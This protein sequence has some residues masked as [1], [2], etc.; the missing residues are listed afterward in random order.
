MFNRLKRL[1]SKYN[2]SSNGKSKWLLLLISVGVCFLVSIVVNYC[3]FLINGPT[4]LG[5]WYNKYWI[6]AVALFA[7]CMLLMVFF[8]H[9]L[10]DKPERLYLALVLCIGCF[11][12]YSFSLRQ[13]SW[14]VAIHFQ[15][16]LEWSDFGLPH[17]V[18][19]AEA[20][21]AYLPPD[22]PSDTTLEAL[23]KWEEELDQQDDGESGFVAAGA[24]K[25]LYKKI[26]SLP[27]SMVY[28]GLSFLGLSFSDRYILS[29]LVYVFIYGIVTYFGMRRLKSGKLIFATIAMFPTSIFIAANYSYDYWVNAFALT[30]AAYL[31]GELQRSD[32]LAKKKNLAIMLGSFFLA[33]GP[34]AIYFPIILLCLLIPRN[35][36]NTR[37]ECNLYRTVTVLLSLLVLMSFIA[38]FFFAIS[39]E[40]VVG[41]MRGG[42][43]VNSGE[44]IRFILSEP[45]RYACILMTFLV[46][47]L[48]PLNS[49]GYIIDLAYLNHAP[50]ICWVVSVTCLL[51]AVVFD[52]EACDKYVN[53][54]RNR[55]A[56]LAGVLLCI[57][58][59][60]TALY[61]S[62]TPVGSPTI[63]GCQFRY[64]LP[65]IFPFCIFIGTS[66]LPLSFAMGN[67]ALINGIYLV[68]LSGSL[69]FA[70]A[71]SVIIAIS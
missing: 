34:K 39:S 66:K 54:H 69:L 35:K 23:D 29:H 13:I 50:A 65:V 11:Y 25:E 9:E 31:V 4:S 24:K 17:S 68:V 8:R 20:Q 56:V 52:K 37:R 16:V 46:N 6:M 60:A 30:G 70:N 26:A 7:F 51:L 42:G 22:G 48:S 57:I 15:Y 18:S 63:Q 49:G 67:R 1:L 14:D 53:T 40:A 44:Q 38:P 61:V 36:F 43:N 10:G 19:N 47:Y 5:T 28:G 59:V 27:S 32:E 45:F 12:A 58:L 55:I 2:Y 33:L 62:F 3:I 64:L 71:M 41:D 21:M